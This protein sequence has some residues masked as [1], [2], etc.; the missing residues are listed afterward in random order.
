MENIRI[1]ILKTIVSN[2]DTKT[3]KCHNTLLNN[4]LFF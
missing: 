1:K 4:A 3:D 2:D